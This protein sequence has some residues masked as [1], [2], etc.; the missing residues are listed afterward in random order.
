MQRILLIKLLISFKLL[1]FFLKLT[2]KGSGTALPGL[3]GEKYFPW[4]KDYLL[5]QIKY[6]IAITGTNGKT[7]TQTILNSILQEK[8]YT[9]L[10]NK[11]GSNMNRGIISELVKRSSITGKLNFD[12]GIFEI[13]EATFPKVVESIKPEVIIITNLFRDQLDAYGEIDRT[14]KF[15]I[16]GIQK[17]PKSK[18]VLNFDDPKVREIK[19]QI[20]NETV[21][22]DLNDKLTENIKFE[23]ISEITNSQIP[24]L[25]DWQAISNIMIGKNCRQDELGNNIF[26]VEIL[27]NKS[28]FLLSGVNLKVTGGYQIYNALSAL[29]AARLMGLDIPTIRKGIE[30]FTPAFGRGETITIKRG[31]KTINFKI[32]LVKNPAGCNLNLDILKPFRNLKLILLLNDNIADGKDVSWIWDCEFEKLNQCDLTDVIF[33]GKRAF[34]MQVRVKYALNTRKFINLKKHIDQNISYSIKTAIELAQ[35]NETIYVLPT[36][37]AML[38]FRKLL[39]QTLE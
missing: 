9:V 4:I 25:N 1:N 32:L 29:A 14:Q 31:K 22:I 19:E 11:A 37:T 34:D 7:T 27:Q 39:G 18:V 24:S 8:G 26:D 12:Y 35:D 3:I 28:R 6:K 10:N 13:E 38:E 33:S 15:I 30:K 17:S 5:D 2:G 21:F 23:S 36:Y 20:T 16:D